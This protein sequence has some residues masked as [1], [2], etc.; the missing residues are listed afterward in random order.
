L[1]VLS[2][3]VCSVLSSFLCYLVNIKQSILSN[4]MEKNR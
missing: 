2:D 4:Y 3:I 1:P